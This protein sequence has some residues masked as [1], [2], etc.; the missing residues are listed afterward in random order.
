MSD[1]NTQYYFAF[2]TNYFKS[3]MKKLGLKD[4]VLLGKLKKK[5]III[6][7]NP[8]SG[9]PMKNVLKNRRRIHIDPFVL[10]YEIND[11]EIRFLDFDHHNKI[12]KKF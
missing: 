4:R 8:T 3:I 12:Y 7:R 9:K 5:I 2:Y 6:L 11:T 10:I 1:D